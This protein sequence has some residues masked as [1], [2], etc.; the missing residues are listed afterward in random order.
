MVL[1]L[2]HAALTLVVIVGLGGCI[3]STPPVRLA[4]PA[5]VGVHVVLERADGTSVAVPSSVTDVIHEALAAR[6]L[7]PT[8][9]PASAFSRSLSELRATPA[10][11]D[12]LRGVAPMSDFT[13][14]VQ[15]N[16]RYFTQ[17]AGR[18]RWDVE[19]QLTLTPRG[20][21]EQARTQDLS[22][23]AHL[24]FEHEGAGDAFKYVHRQLADELALLLDRALISAPEPKA[25]PPTESQAKPSR[26]ALYFV[27]IDRFA[28]SD[29]ATTAMADPT[30]WF[31]GDLAGLSAHLDWLEDLGVGAIWLSP[32]FATRQERFF[33]HAAFH[34]Y[35][36]TNLDRVEPRFGTREDLAGLAKNLQQRGLGLWLDLVLNHVGPDAPVTK[37]KPSWFRAQ[38]TITN[39]QDPTQLEEGQVH[40]LPDLNQANPEVYAFLTATSTMW[41]ELLKPTGLRLDAV[42]HISPAFWR[43]FNGEMTAA[44][45]GV[46]LLAEILDGDPIA[47][48]SLA[49]DGGFSAIFDF[50]LHY[51]L[52]DTF[53]RGAGA[54]PLGTALSVNLAL[55]DA[56]IARGEAPLERYAFLD[57]HDLPRVMSVCGGDVAKV[58]LALDALV[59]LPAHPALTWGTEVGLAGQNEPE[60]RAPMRFDAAHPLVGHTRAALSLRARDKALTGGT[61]RIETWDSRGALSFS[62]SVGTL[63]TLVTVNPTAEAIRLP[64]LKNLGLPSIEAPPM[65][66][67]RRHFDATRPPSS[68]P[69]SVTIVVKARPAGAVRLVGATPQLGAWSP[70]R[71]PASEDGTFHLKLAPGR[72][73]AVKLVSTPPDAPPRWEKRQ[74]RY[75]FIAGETTLTLTWEEA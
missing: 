39:W 4:S 16:A 31:G 52:I 59:T 32:P 50:G 1:N 14:L 40:G 35:W 20:R 33:G 25:A 74:N 41:V 60:N 15:A 29:S 19:V 22:V 34:G 24:M 27:M 43:R 53:C 42:K 23:A 10:R 54:G 47:V 56:A 72:L 44:R 37:E 65:S 8:D 9:I 66:V 18:F 2:R 26:D 49:R 13:L 21:P 38:R 48:D 45:P 68:D 3:A 55:D 64:A 67:T 73:Y 7:I 70:D 51:A 6:N 46:G 62:R 61:T 12:A 58:G 57:N 71:A 5:T 28:R 36:T 75:L 17:I 63:G 69:V 30:A 11:V